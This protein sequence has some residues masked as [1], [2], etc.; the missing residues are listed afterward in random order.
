MA[1]ELKVLAEK[2]KA[3]GLDV[4]EDAAKILVEET[5]NWVSE[6]A[7]KSE[8]KVDDLVVAILPIVKPHILNAVDKI[9]GVKG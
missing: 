5:L 7:L 4:A 3:K 6:E 1:Y 2:L 8:N 9:D